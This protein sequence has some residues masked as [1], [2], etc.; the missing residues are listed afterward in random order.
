MLSNKK[1]IQIS[2]IVFLAIEL[3]LFVLVQTASGTA[4]T[5]VSF[6]VVVLSCLFALLMCEKSIDYAL[7]QGALVATVMADLF[8]VVLEPMNREAGMVFFS[9]A[10][11][12]YFV[13][14]YL[15]QDKKRRTAHL[16]VRLGVIIVALVATVLV[17]G[18]DTDFLSLISLFYY[19]NLITSVVFALMEKR[20]ML[21]FAIGLVLFAMCD[22]VIGLSTMAELY[23]PVSEGGLLYSIIHPGFNLAWIFYV[24]SQALISYSLAHKRLT[25]K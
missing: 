3:V 23:I 13:K 22:A 18:E 1:A 12:C 10:Q 2:S 11:I 8:L 24:P 9:I 7:T 19:A 6:G 15:C 4:N 25:Q 17:L 5:V 21:I 14:I 20:K 16:F